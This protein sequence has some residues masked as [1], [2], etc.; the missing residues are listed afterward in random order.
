MAPASYLRATIPEPELAAITSLLE[1]R[2]LN[3]VD[4]LAYLAA[5]VTAIVSGHKQSQINGLQPWNHS[6]KKPAEDCCWPIPVV[7]SVR[8]VYCLSNAKESR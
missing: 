3:A 8:R 2:K 4:P 1:T 6:R 5:T 7:G